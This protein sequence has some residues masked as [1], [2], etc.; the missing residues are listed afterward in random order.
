MM[1]SVKTKRRVSVAVQTVFLLLIAIFFLVPLYLTVVNA[2]KDGGD[3]MSSPMSLPI[4]PV[5]DGIKRILENK[6]N[7]IFAMYRNSILLIIFAVPI[8]VAI[9]SLASYYIARNKTRAS[10][11]LSIYFLVGLM[12]PY[13]IVYI[14]LSI[15][16]RALGLSFGLPLLIFV[17]VS[18]GISFATFMYSNFI[19]SVPVELEEAAAL[20]G[21]SKFY[22]FWKILFPLLK[23]CTATVVIFNG[24]SVWNDFMTPLLLGQV[25][26]ITVGIYTAIGPHS[27]DWAL[28]FG[29]LLFAMLP[30]II[31]FL[32]MQKQFIAGLTAGAAKG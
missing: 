6:S 32:F 14:P 5:L 21:A 7:S 18:G 3:V 25:K 16:V 30:V 31:A 29:Y 13:V 15:L 27:T 2:F 11:F 9:S 22:T 12:V 26:T 4:P 17:F 19:K 10:R 20:D 1:H 23:P 8:N 28:V 24:L